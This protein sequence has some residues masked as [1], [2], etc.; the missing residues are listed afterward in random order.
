MKRVMSLVD[1]QREEV[2][3][4]ELTQDRPI[5]SL[6]FAGRYRLVDFAL[7]SMVTSGIRNVG[8]LL[9]ENKARSIL[10]H[11]RSGKDWDLARH[12]KGLFYLPPVRPE[13]GE[14]A[15]DLRNIY[16]NLNFVENSNEEYV[17][18]AR[19]TSVYNID[20]TKVLKFHIDNGADVTVVTSKAWHSDPC[21]GLIVEPGENGRIRD[22]AIKPELKEGE[23][24]SLGIFLM[25]KELFCNVVRYAFEHGGTDFRRDAIL[26]QATGLKFYTYI[27]DGF[28]AR[29]CSTPAFYLSNLKML[30]QSVWEELFMKENAPII[31]KV[32]DMSPTEYKEG[33]KVKNSLIANGCEIHGTVEN[34][35]IFRNVTVAP[36]AVIRNSVVMED[37]VLESQAEIEYVITD[38]E[39]TITEGKHLRGAEN[40]PVMVGKRIT[41]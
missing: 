28:A 1:L 13:N 7:S 37:C 41:I 33:A 38:K 35:V 34:S 31:T 36:G 23:Y 24:R 19:A 5:A 27:H 30:D 39:V 18:L 40:F 2:Y 4:K 9:P 14:K 20:F 26:K 21:S 25:S 16:Y 3:I 10:D 6:P 17:L 29:I 8:V 15:S 22:A 11:L 32:K 12:H